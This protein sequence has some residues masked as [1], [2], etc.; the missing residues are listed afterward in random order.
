M[1]DNPSTSHRAKLSSS[2]Q[3]VCHMPCGKAIHLWT[4]WQDT[5][6]ILD[7]LKMKREKYKVSMPSVGWNQFNSK[8]PSSLYNLCI[9]LTQNLVHTG[10]SWVTFSSWRVMKVQRLPQSPTHSHYH[11]GLGQHDIIWSSQHRL[12][13]CWSTVHT[14]LD[15]TFICKEEWWYGTTLTTFPVWFVCQYIEIEVGCTC[16]RN[17]CNIYFLTWLDSYQ[18]QLYVYKNVK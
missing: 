4:Y 3:A 5:P 6:Y 16:L 1:E 14:V 18:I 15:K 8:W 13:W 2:S 11:L 7:L 12:S 17:L 9:S 10:G